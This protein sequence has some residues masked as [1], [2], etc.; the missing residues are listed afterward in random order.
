MA[1]E[2]KMISLSPK[3][4]D[5]VL[6]LEEL[7]VE[8]H[9]HLPDIVKSLSWE[10]PTQSDRIKGIDRDTLR[11]KAVRTLERFDHEEFRFFTDLQEQ[12]LKA[13]SQWNFE[14]LHVL[15]SSAN[16]MAAREGFFLSSRRYPHYQEFLKTHEQ[17]KQ[18]I[19]QLDVIRSQVVDLLFES[20]NID[21][22][23]PL[24]ERLL[25]LLLLHAAY[26]MHE[27]AQHDIYNTLIRLARQL[28]KGLS[29]QQVMRLCQN[30]HSLLK[31]DPL[32]RILTIQHIEARFSYSIGEEFIANLIRLQSKAKNASSESQLF[33][34]HA[35]CATRLSELEIGRLIFLHSNKPDHLPKSVS[36][37]PA[38]KVK[39]FGW[40]N[41][42]LSN[43]TQSP[44]AVHV[45]ID[46]DKLQLEFDFAEKKKTV[47]LEHAQEQLV[48]HFSYIYRK[49]LKTLAISPLIDAGLFMKDIQL[50]YKGNHILKNISVAVRTGEMVAVVGPSGCGKSTML[51]MLAG[52]LE[53]SSGEI[54]FNG[55][56]INKLEEFS[57]ICTYIPQD[58]ILFRE[59]TVHESIDNSLK[60]KVKATE[61]EYQE[62][63]KSTIEVL[64]LERTEFLKIGNEGEKGI[65]GGQRKRVNIASTIVADMK[66][67]LL[68]DEPTSGLDPATD[69]EIMQLL[70]Q[71]SRQGHIVMV[72]THNL[73][74]ESL[75]YFDQ[76][77][78]LD[79]GG[80]VQFVG[81]EQRARYFF[82]IRSTH[83]LFQKMKEHSKEDYCE[84]F[85]KTPESKSLLLNIERAV[86]RQSEK[87]SFSKSD[88]IKEER[89]PN[90]WSNF[91]RFI[92]RELRRKSRD[93]I[94]I[95]MCC[96]QPLLISLFIG[97]N[98]DGPVPNAIFSLL[99]ATLWI[100]AISGVREINTEM[101]QLKRDFLYGTSLSG[102]LGAKVIS[103][104][105]FSAFQVIVLAGTLFLGEG[106]FSEP[107]NF[108]FLAAFSGLLILNLFGISL[109]LFLSASIK[110]AL[111]AV[112][113]LPVLL[114]PLLIMGGALIRHHQVDGLQWWAMKLNPLRICYESLL[115]SGENVLRPSLEDLKPRKL[116]QLTQQKKLWTEFEEKL[117]LYKSNPEAY[118]QKFQKVDLNDLFSSA[119]SD[120][121]NSEKL[122]APEPPS[123]VVEPHLLIHRPDLWLQGQKCLSV[124]PLEKDFWG[125]EIFPIRAPKAFSES[126]SAQGAT[127]M[128]LHHENKDISIYRPVEYF[129]LPLIEIFCLHLAMFFILMFRLS[130]KN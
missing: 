122:K 37:V 55:E 87:L 60:L 84:K 6:D 109:G 127:G 12:I 120:S 42:G 62:R 124:D 81:K 61:G 64:G 108:N 27:D 41:K 67:I 119:L 86:T 77:L 7:D 89:L 104:F 53:R 111:A 101:P 68:F 83:L 93:H 17:C 9:L 99:A 94:F 22:A 56:N 80:K 54:I 44:V 98:F 13:T 125:T 66:P 4:C 107:F 52:I 88:S 103:G 97:W 106:Y 123:D 85:S 90:M 100:G 32:L 115:F 46:G 34:K 129:I 74:A 59:L 102:Y 73:S 19:S 72:V 57:K 65:S 117:E 130:R 63:I 33:L 16:L 58:D 91:F 49:D 39:K 35:L 126:L 114:I 48:D 24:G 69:V 50:S 95:L 10:W 96:I 116:E 28:F 47:V 43:L 15:T 45:N 36:L 1:V 20:G 110:S 70:R 75:A 128:F 79:R 30:I 8:K 51:T 76:I 118:R 25:E 29:F 78:V 71:L 11:L 21:S 3:L 18:L 38:H 26:D 31:D 40:S 23:V 14:T 82:N 105:G 92:E 2:P 121:A 5:I 113:L 112:G